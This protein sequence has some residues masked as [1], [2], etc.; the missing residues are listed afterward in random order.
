[1]ASLAGSRCIRELEKGADRSQIQCSSTI[2]VRSACGT[3]SQAF[4][5]S[6]GYTTNNYGSHPASHC[7]SPPA[8]ADYSYN[9]RSFGSQRN[10]RW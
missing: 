6:T 5:S 8:T 10:I 4:N 1:M 7:S 3:T 2:H 9:I